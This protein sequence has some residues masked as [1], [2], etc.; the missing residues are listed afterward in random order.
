[1]SRALARALAAESISRGKPLEWFEALY[2]Q[3]EGDASV[4]PWADLCTNPNLVEWCNRTEF[5]P[6]GKLALVIG[7]GLGDDAEALQSAGAQVTAFD[8]SETCIAWCRRRFPGSAVDHVAADLFAPPA[9]W[10]RAFDFVLEA[11]TW[12]V[13][14]P[15]LRPA[16]IRQVAEFVAADGRLLAIVRGRD[17]A[18]DGGQMPWRIAHEELDELI[19][20]G[21][22]EVSFEDYLDAEEPPVRRFRIEYRR[23]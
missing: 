14:P 4:I 22:T 15:D 5:D 6:R 21:L 10:Q 2:R 9:A 23:H 16:A 1:M 8:I 12:Q 19:E 3:A 11:Y 18:D 13:L 7:C 20:A 17:A